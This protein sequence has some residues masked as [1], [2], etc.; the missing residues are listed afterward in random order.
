VEIAR[1]FAELGFKLVATRG[2]AAAIETGGMRCKTVFKVNEGRP[3][4]TDL[5][6]AG[7]LPARRRSKISGTSGAVRC[8]SGAV[9]HDAE[10]GTRAATEALASMK[11][12]PI[13]VWNLQGIHDAAEAKS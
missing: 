7:A 3:S 1:R 11:R 9:H 2:T 4:A 5:L 13:R 12:D 6:K 8:L 10:C